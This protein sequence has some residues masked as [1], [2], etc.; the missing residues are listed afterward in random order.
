VLLHEGAD[1]QHPLVDHD[2]FPRPDVVV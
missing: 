1:G 2:I